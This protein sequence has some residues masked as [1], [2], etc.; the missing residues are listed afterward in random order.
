M[1]SYMCSTDLCVVCKVEPDFVRVGVRHFRMHA[2][3]RHS[4]A[5]LSSCHPSYRTIII[6]S[7]V[8]V[9]ISVSVN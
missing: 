8:E 5:A 7:L 1:A 6:L 3:I 9:W 2:Y 4:A